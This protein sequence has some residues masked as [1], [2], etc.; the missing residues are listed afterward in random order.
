MNSFV[1]FRGKAYLIIN[2]KIYEDLINLNN[3]LKYVRIIKSHN[4][5]ISA[6]TKVNKM[7]IICNLLIAI[8]SP[9]EINLLLIITNRG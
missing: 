1:Y 4:K 9:T 6:K 2:K 8:L 5:N 7:E 3:K